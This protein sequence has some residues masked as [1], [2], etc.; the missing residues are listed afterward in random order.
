MVPKD[1]L[2]ILIGT[3][4]YTSIAGHEKA[5]TD[6]KVITLLKKTIMTLGDMNTR[7]KDLREH[8]PNATF[9]YS[10]YFGI[11]QIGDNY[12]N[13]M[14]IENTRSLRTRLHTTESYYDLEYGEP[15]IFEEEEYNIPILHKQRLLI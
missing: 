1:T 7:L 3:S 14:G 11:K 5:L 6:E 8:F 13:P 10:D 9:H 4:G 15:S 2:L 12:R